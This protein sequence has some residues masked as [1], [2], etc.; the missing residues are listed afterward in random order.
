MVL[1]EVS[2]VPS[3]S[4]AR[5]RTAPSPLPLWGSTS[6]LL[7]LELSAAMRHFPKGGAERGLRLLIIHFQDERRC[8]NRDDRTILEANAVLV[9]KYLVHVEGTRS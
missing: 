1:L 2:K 8:T 3:R 9:A 4:T 7:H 5:K 6:T